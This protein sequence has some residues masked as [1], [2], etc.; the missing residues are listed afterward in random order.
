[1]LQCSNQYFRSNFNE[2]SGGEVT[3]GQNFACSDCDL[4]SKNEILMRNHAKLIHKVKF[5]LT[6][7]KNF[8]VFLSLY[9]NDI[10]FCRFCYVYH[11]VAQDF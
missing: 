9:G 11:F 5:F 10:L 8:L 3:L 2:R 1:M 7:V 6:G 4:S